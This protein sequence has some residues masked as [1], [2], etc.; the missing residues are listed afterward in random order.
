MSSTPT[1]ESTVEALANKSMIR[2]SGIPPTS[3]PLADTNCSNPTVFG[4]NGWHG[5]LTKYADGAIVLEFA[6]ATYNI[7]GRIEFDDK[8]VPFEKLAKYCVE[9]D[10]RIIRICES[11]ENAG[12]TDCECD[13]PRQTRFVYGRSAP[14]DGER[15]GRVK[16]AIPCAHVCTSELMMI[17]TRAVNIHKIRRRI[18]K[19][20]QAL[21]S[22]LLAKILQMH[23]HKSE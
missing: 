16:G 11:K 5:L 8:V 3:R 7:G 17:Y 23:V 1:E 14:D 9:D 10:D 13:S 6:E 22:D 19:S 18:A 4:V 21:H 20:I 2:L 12:P 15:F